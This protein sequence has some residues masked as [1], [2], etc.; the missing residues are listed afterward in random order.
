MDQQKPNLSP[1]QLNY[2]AL[3]AQGALTV[4]TGHATERALARRGLI[5]SV[6]VNNLLSPGLFFPNR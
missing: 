5:G 3:A 1:A 4:G 6:G 2:L